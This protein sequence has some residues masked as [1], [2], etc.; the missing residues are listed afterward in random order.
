M[1]FAMTGGAALFLV[2]LLG[3]AQTA[4]EWKLDLAQYGLV[5]ASCAWYPGHIEFL[6]DDHLVVSA[7]VAYTCDKSDRGK[8]TETRITEIDLQGHELA[9]T[10]RTDVAEL[11]AGPIGYF[12]VCTGDRVELLS[13][14]LK[15][16]RSIAL[17]GTGPSGGCYFGGGLSPSRTAMVIT[18]PLNSQFRLYDGSSNDPIAEITT[19][20]GQS[21]RAVTDGGF[22]VCT[23]ERKQCEVVSSN[24]VVHSF[25]MPQLG[26]ASGYYIVGFV[27][28]DRLLVGSFDGKRLYAETPTGDTVTMGDVSKIRPPFI[29]S[30]DTEMSAVVPRR[31]LYRVDGCLLGDFDDCYGVV[32]RRFA[33]FDSQTSRMLFR[34]SY[35]P[36][37]D[38]KISP[39]G[40]IV[41]E[42]DGPVVHLFRLP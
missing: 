36:G 13:R 17:S 4:Q 1:K 39:N 21:V 28:S 16:A 18:G 5:R 14:D 22:L 11:V 41:M 42:Q 12:T 31:I 23:K 33:V 37:A 9:A 3:R 32:F 27:A 40:H 24:G 34:H 35:A 8:L 26:G 19:S 38:L 15:V 6:D 29:D 7:P 10:R 25:A 30:S 20:K 2:A